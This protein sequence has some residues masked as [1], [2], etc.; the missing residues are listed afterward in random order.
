MD[1][2]LCGRPE[3]DLPSSGGSNLAEVMCLA[4]LSLDFYHTLQEFPE[5]VTSP[6]WEERRA[7]H[8]NDIRQAMSVVRRHFDA[9]RQIL[10]EFVTAKGVDH[11][12]PAG[13]LFSPE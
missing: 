6:P 8:L 3:V 2:T 10:M 4:S 11:S 1:P 9:D 5:A 13:R 7:E 12:T